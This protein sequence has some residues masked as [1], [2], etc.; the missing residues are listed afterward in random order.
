VAR[1]L[2]DCEA[3]PVKLPVGETEGETLTLGLGVEELETARERLAVRL[4][5][6]EPVALWLP[7]SEAPGVGVEARRGDAEAVE[8]PDTVRVWLRVL[9]LQGDTPPLAVEFPVTDEEAVAVPL[10]V[11]PA[12]GL[13]VPPAAT[14]AL[15]EPVA[16]GLGVGLEERHCEYVAEAVTLPVLQMLGEAEPQ[17]EGESEPEADCV[18]EV[19]AEGVARSTGEEVT[20]ALPVVEG[21]WGVKVAPAAGLRVFPLPMLLLGV[22]EAESEEDCEGEPE[23]LAEPPLARVAETEG[24]SVLE[25]L[26]EGEL[27]AVASRES[28]GRGLEEA[29]GVPLRHCVMVGV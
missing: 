29:V 17:G 10:L 16:Q 22:V 13:E 12:A 26:T 19:E 21:A 3:V 8:E 23:L 7:L 28:V 4:V 2:A 24:E 14:V 11:P 18:E 27:E 5:E 25:G 20:E 15:R 1:P 6:A 9:E